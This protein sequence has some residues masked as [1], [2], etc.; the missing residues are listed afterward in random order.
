MNANTNM[1][2]FDPTATDDIVVTCEACGDDVCSSKASDIARDDVFALYAQQWSVSGRDAL[3]CPA[4]IQLI[5]SEF[6]P[7][8]GSDAAYENRFD[9]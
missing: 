8:D 4:C 9:R 6:Q 3:F 2:T 1:I 5:K 7:D